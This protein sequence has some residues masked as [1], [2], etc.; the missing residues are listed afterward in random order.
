MPCNV[1]RAQQCRDTIPGSIAPGRFIPLNNGTLLDKERKLVWMRCSVGQSWDNHTMTCVGHPTPL[2]WY[3]AMRSAE[4]LARL[5]KQAWRLPSIQELS[6]ITEMRCA[7]PAIDLHWFPNTPAAHFWTGT[8][9]V[10]QQGHF[11]LLQFLTG[12]NNTDSAK[13]QALVRLVKPGE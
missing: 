7:D 2:N 4:T 1:S 8:P 3:R 11:W 12:E 6:S 13:R 5:S 9:F 10:N